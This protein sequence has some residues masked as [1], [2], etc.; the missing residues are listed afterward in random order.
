MK[1]DPQNLK[2]PLRRIGSSP[3]S[4]ESTPRIKGVPLEGRDHPLNGGIKPK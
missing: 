3:Q 4:D 2:V 1:K